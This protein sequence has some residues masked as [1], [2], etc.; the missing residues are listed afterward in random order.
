MS[1]PLMTIKPCPLFPL[2]PEF[3]CSNLPLLKARTRRPAFPPPDD[4]VPITC[5]SH[6]VLTGFVNWRRP[7]YFPSLFFGFL[8][9]FPIGELSFSTFPFCAT[10]LTAAFCGL[11][12]MFS[13]FSSNPYFLPPFISR[14]TFEAG[15][16]GTAWN[17][18]RI[19]S[20]G[21]V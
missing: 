3:P 7:P 6:H 9:L 5:R 10:N 18:L 2:R 12:Q 16:S 14:T 4:L 21:S 13:E 20:S 8:Q 17:V 19:P 15:A 1:L 11:R